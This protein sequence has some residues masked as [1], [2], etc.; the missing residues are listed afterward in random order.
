MRR[1]VADIY[2]HALVTGASAGLGRAFAEILLADGVRVW[3]TARAPARL[4]D[5]AVRFPELFTPLVLDLDNPDAA[6]AAFVRAAKSAGGSFDL[7]INNAGSGVFGTFD[8]LDGDVWQR[9]VGGMLGTTMRLTHLALNGMRR[10]G[11]GCI[12]NVSSLAVDFPLPFMSGYNVAKAG[13]SALTESLIVET[14]GSDIKVIDF[15]P[16]DYRTE[17]N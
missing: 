4:T 5:L 1:S 7:V 13:L 9:Q 6:E 17:F 2:P 15:R 8:G 16:G 3:G 10:R 14:R 11:K 12:V